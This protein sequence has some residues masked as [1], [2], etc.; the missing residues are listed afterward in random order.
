MYFILL[1]QRHQLFTIK[2]YY[3][4]INGNKAKFRI[5][6]RWSKFMSPIHDLQSILFGSSIQS[7]L[8][9]HMLFLFFSANNDPEMPHEC[10]L[11]PECDKMCDSKLTFPEYL[12]MASK[13][14]EV[15]MTFH[16]LNVW[17]SLWFLSVDDCW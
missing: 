6:Y 12:L 13:F 17:I 4:L 16:G 5:V 3:N 2:T 9:L 10:G 1:K 15:Q 14:L 8:W 7:H 11:M